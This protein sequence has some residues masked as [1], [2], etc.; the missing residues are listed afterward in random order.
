MTEYKASTDSNYNKKVREVRDVTSM[1]EYAAGKVLINA[2]GDVKLAIE[3][4][5]NNT[6]VVPSGEPTAQAGMP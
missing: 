3:R 5:F 2:Q 4:F 6:T 1:D